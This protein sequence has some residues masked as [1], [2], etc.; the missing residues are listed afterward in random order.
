MAGAKGVLLVSWL[1]LF[2]AFGA[3]FPASR[4][5]TVSSIHKQLRLTKDPRTD[6]E[7]H[8]WPSTCG[9]RTK[10]R[11]P[12]ASDILKAAIDAIDGNLIVTK[13]NIAKSWNV[14]LNGR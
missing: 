11:N 13:Q 1:L 8:K 14:E 12:I 9:R 4:K 10:D 2:A 5:S 6:T 3:A 7:D